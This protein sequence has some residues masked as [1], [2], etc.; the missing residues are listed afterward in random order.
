LHRPSGWGRQRA[1]SRLRDPAG[2]PRATCRA[3]A[4]SHAGR[5]S[6][7]GLGAFDYEFD[8]CGQSYS[9]VETTGRLTG[10][11]PSKTYYIYTDNDFP[12]SDGSYPSAKVTANA[13]GD[14]VLRHRDLGLP[15]EGQDC[16][17]Y[18]YRADSRH[19]SDPNGPMYYVSTDPRST[20]NPPDHLVY[21][22]K[23]AELPNRLSNPWTAQGGTRLQDDGTTLMS[24]HLTAIGGSIEYQFGGSGDGNFC[25]ADQGSSIWCTHTSGTGNTMWMQHDGN[26][27]V[28]SAGG[29]ALWSTRT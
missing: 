8:T 21:R 1:L 12:G 27:V 29:E 16:A 14:I 19:P 22:I 15:G 28:Y 3:A 23:A 17:I 20:A 18:P 2:R 25:L 11:E 26:L 9:H 6:A 4:G 5:L 10:Y 7:R 13:D 24:N